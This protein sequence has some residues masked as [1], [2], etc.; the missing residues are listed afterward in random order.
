MI[1]VNMELGWLDANINLED[2]VDFT[3]RSFRDALGCFATGVVVVTTHPKGLK[4]IG[5]TVNSFASVSLEP[6]LVL[7]SLDRES[8]TQ[9][10]FLASDRFAVNVLRADQEALSI[11]MSIQGEHDLRDDEYE[12]WEYETWETGAPILTDTLAQFDCEV[13]QT[14]DGGDHVI[15][16]GRVLRFVTGRGEP[17]LFSCGEY[18]NIKA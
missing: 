4:P 10:S 15:F 9:G 14:I 7:W 18:R 6:P 3:T 13:I 17:L 12:T 5:L 1:S 11:R 16:L 8:D 2:S